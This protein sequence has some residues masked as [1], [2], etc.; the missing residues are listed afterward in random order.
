MALVLS[1]A[2]GTAVV[3]K[4]T[5]GL[6]TYTCTHARTHT[7]VFHPGEHSPH[8]IK[9]AAKKTKKFFLWTFFLYPPEPILDSI[10]TAS[11]RSNHLGHTKGG[12]EHQL[13]DD[14]Y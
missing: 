7:K 2:A 10:K 3:V 9:R 13:Y 8:H 6:E 12:V 5:Y 11:A 14:S 4:H 1:A